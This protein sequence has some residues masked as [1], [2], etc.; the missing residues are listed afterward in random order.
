MWGGDSERGE[1]GR[2][3]ESVVCVHAP[4]HAYTLVYLLKK[5]DPTMHSLPKLV[6]SQGDLPTSVK[7]IYFK[8]H[9]F[10]N[11]YGALLLLFGCTKFV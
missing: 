2:V 8:D 5:L 4:V 9:P 10:E 7:Y 6:F 3:L 11:K 1:E